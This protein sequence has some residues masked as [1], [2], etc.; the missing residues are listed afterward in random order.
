MLAK[1]NR[2]SQKGWCGMNYLFYSI[3][4]KEQFLS[5]FYRI[6]NSIANGVTPVSN[7]L[8]MARTNLIEL[9]PNLIIQSILLVVTT[10]LIEQID[11]AGMFALVVVLIVNSTSS[12]LSWVLMVHLKHILRCKCL[13]RFG[14][15]ICEKNIAVLESMEYQ[16]V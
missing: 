11:L 2:N 6:K 8:R 12:T 14:L 4:R 7:E 3:K 16:S 15:E 1:S 13:K 5:E 9:F 10:L